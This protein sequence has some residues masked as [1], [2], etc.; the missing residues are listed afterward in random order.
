MFTPSYTFQLS[1]F[2]PI[3]CTMKIINRG[4][5]HKYS[6]CGCQVKN[7]PSFGNPFS[8]HEMALLGVFL[9]LSSTNF[10][11]IFTKDSILADKNIV[12]IIFPKFEFLRKWDRSKT[13][14]LSCIPFPLN[15]A[16]IKERQNSQWKKC[17][18]QA[19]QICQ[20]QDSFFSPV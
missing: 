9:G 17:S 8:T 13:L 5:F 3:K 12:W 2:P 11:E 19:M 7:F 14:T 20:S 6:I 1:P 15:M 16:K 4:K 18:H 10:D